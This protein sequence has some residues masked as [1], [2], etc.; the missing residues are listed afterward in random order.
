MHRPAAHARVVQSLREVVGRAGSEGPLRGGSMIKPKDYPRD[1]IAKLA[2]E[3]IERHGGPQFARVYFKF[4]CAQ[5]GERCQFDEPNAL[6][7]T[8]E[9]HACGHVTTVE[10]AGFSLLLSTTGVPL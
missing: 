10:I 1:E 2:V 3:A 8:G 6:Y 7:E 4:T 5:C 9:C